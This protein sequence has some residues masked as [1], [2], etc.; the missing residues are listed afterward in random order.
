MPEDELLSQRMAHKICDYSDECQSNGYLMSWVEIV[1]I[2]APVDLLK[3]CRELIAYSQ[4]E[5]FID[6]DMEEKGCLYCDARPKTKHANG[7]KLYKLLS[8]LDAAIKEE[9][10]GEDEN[11]NNT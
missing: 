9:I 6:P 10:G 2:I 11:I 7:C 3:E 8:R 1:K 5:S 4:Y